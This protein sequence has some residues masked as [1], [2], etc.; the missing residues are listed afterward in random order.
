MAGHFAVVAF[1]WVVA[2]VAVGVHA[3][4][5][6]RSPFLWGILTLLTGLVGL[7][8]YIVVIGTK[9]DDPN[10][11]ES[12]TVCPNC[13]A[14]HTEAPSY[15]SE[16]GEPLE[17]ADETRRASVLRSG[18]K[19]YCGNCHSRIELGTDVCPKCESVF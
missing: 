18:S 13:S 7:A 14:R 3:M 6:D 4:D 17:T 8:A 19:A 16:C 1:L 5:H 9:Y 2:G 12:V 10:R 15:C 11:D